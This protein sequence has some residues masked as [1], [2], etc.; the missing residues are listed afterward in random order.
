MFQ[1][2]RS[3]VLDLYRDT[4]GYP[5]AER[6]GLSSQIRRAAISI[7]ANIA[8]GAARRSKKEFSQFLSVARGSATELNLLLD[9]ACQTGTASLR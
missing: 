3:L 5:A 9:V 6:F 1:V 2:S 4:S 7:P 8:E